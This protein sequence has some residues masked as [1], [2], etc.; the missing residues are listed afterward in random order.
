[1]VA[2]QPDGG[3][4]ARAVELHADSIDLLLTE[5]VLG[6]LLAAPRR[7]ALDPQTLDGPIRGDRDTT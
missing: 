3:W 4:L 6:E 1:V 2:P 5:G 7:H